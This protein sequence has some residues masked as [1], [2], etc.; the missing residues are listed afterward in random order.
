MAQSKTMLS[1]RYEIVSKIG[2]GG[3]SDVYKA[4][5]LKLNR[6]VAVK[7]LKA[8]YAENRSFVSKFRAEAQS[9]AGLMHPNIVNV[10][11]VGEDGGLY[12]IVME[13]VEG[14][15]LKHY[16]EKKL[17]LSYREAVSIAIQVS[18]GLESAHNNH[19]IHRDIKP[20]NIIISKDGKVKVTDF[21]IA[22]AATSDTITSNVMGSVHYTSP[23]QA[24]GG[25]SDEKSDIYS[26]GIVLFEMVT[27]R[28]P[29]DGDTA[30]S[31][32]IK[33]IQEPIPSPREFVDDIPI[34][35][36]HIIY[37]CCEKNADR[38][39]AT[40]SE[41]VA[42]LKRSLTNPDEDFVQLI[43]MGGLQGATKMMTVED[44]SEIKQR[45]GVMTG[46]S[47]TDLKA[48]G[49]VNDSP[50]AVNYYSGEEDAG[51]PGHEEAEGFERG[52]DR[53]YEEDR[54]R[55]ER[56]GDNR[57]GEEDSF[58]EIE[59]RPVIKGKAGNKGSRNNQDER[60]R[61]KKSPGRT[62]ADSRKRRNED[63]Y[64]GE[65]D[66]MDPTLE[67]LMTV[68]GILAAIIIIVIIVILVRR[69]RGLS[70]EKSESG[71][72]EEQIETVEMINVIGIPLS[73]AKNA[74]TDLGLNVTNSSQPS[75]EV[76]K[77]NVI[78]VTDEK[79]KLL[80]EGDELER[81]SVVVLVVSSGENGVTVPD[82]VGL[83]RA[84][85]KVKLEE[86][87]FKMEIA[88]DDP[89]M[90][91][92]IAS[93]S[94]AAGETAEEGSTVTVTF[95]TPKT[96]EGSIT[97]P[98]IV[99]MTETEAKTALTASKLSFTSVNEGN[100]DTV[101]AGVVMSQSPEAGSKVD[102]GASV[103]FV[104]SLGP[105]APA[106]YGGTFNITAPPGYIDG[107]QATIV[108]TS[109]LDNSVL[110][111]GQVT[112]FPVPVVIAGSLSPKGILTVSYIKVTPGQENDDGTT[113]APSSVPQ[114]ETQELT[115][116]QQ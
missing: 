55:E 8:E 49:N 109:A 72:R 110:Y 38:R 85:A 23:E 29:F 2:S 71:T 52:Y 36:E 62:K 30:V 66:D 13:L 53:G 97:V 102:E 69:I 10:Y 59:R 76:A 100:S 77:G 115:F 60:K 89:I 4:A 88:G 31:I 106:L 98:N 114:T 58:E 26:M 17:R 37:K 95:G 90:E 32:A 54:Y 112:S 103:D 67:K 94:P 27:G 14:I 116:T 16:I 84:E 35:V 87:G 25:Y 18:M 61:R 15:T 108:V 46:L 43:P 79:G 40:M 11:D 70:A 111:N 107:T 19:I 33:H 83:S 22:R 7:V 64:A 21:G 20:Q 39:Y 9:A 92:S 91:D 99:G 1:D 51:Y 24:R 42:D 44:L 47:D 57:Y 82:V 93:Q 68:L 73:E 34:S 104:V 28:V 48:F 101:P 3:M 6:F 41:L 5:D 80:S 12:Y 78:S 81:D 45:T 105:A 65:D 96:E 86:Q 75:S 113:S 74:L 63:D 50:Y 56:Y